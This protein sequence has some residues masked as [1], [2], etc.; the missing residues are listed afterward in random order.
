[1][2]P[3]GHSLPKTTPIG[4]KTTQD[5]KT[6]EEEQATPAKD[7]ATGTGQGHPLEKVGS[8][9]EHQRTIH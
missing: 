1:M 3:N 4:T 2:L 6:K 9:K 8:Q 7:K 5:P